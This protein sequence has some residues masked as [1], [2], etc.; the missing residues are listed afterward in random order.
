MTREQEARRKW[1]QWRRGG[2]GGSD[3]AG[4]LNLSPWSSPF[5]V[6]WS[7][8]REAE[9]NDSPVLKRGRLLEDA[10][11]QWAGNELGGLVRGS[12]VVHPEFEWARGTPDGWSDVDEGLEAKTTRFFD[13][14]YGW[15]PDGSDEVPLHYRIQCLWYMTVTNAKVWRLAA[16]G[17]L[18]DEWRIYTIEPDEEVQSR[19]LEVSGRFWK[20][21]VEADVAPEIDTSPA[22][23]AY[24]RERFPVSTETVVEA[25]KEDL[26]L[27]EAY[28]KARDEERT[29]KKKKDELA[30]KIKE[31]IG[32]S[33]GLQG[34]PG[35]LRASW[36]R[37]E[38][39]SVDWKRFRS[40][41]PHFEEKVAEY[42]RTSQLDRLTVNRR[43]A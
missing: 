19:L 42:E 21:H 28:T 37:Y 40:E 20:E 27:L 25:S 22:A 12:P 36:S 13:P 9:E 6:W 7:K 23:S 35:E 32:E 5:S 17:T 34:E 26:E 30:V 10:I 29:S 38:R 39:T 11:L 4:L 31:R 16:F 43:K 41:N 1:L 15:G 14:E 3:V 18:Q 24:L 2:L 8:V 33:K